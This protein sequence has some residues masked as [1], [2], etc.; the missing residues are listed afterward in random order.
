MQRGVYRVEKGH[1]S[2]QEKKT[3]RF[4]DLQFAEHYSLHGT[5]EQR[6]ASEFR[7]PLFEGFTMPS[8]LVC[9]ETAALVK[10]LL[11]RPLSVRLSE[12]PADIQLVEAFAPA[13]APGDGA[14]A[15]GRSWLEFAQLQRERAFVARQ[16]F[17]DR[18]E[19]PS[20]WETAEVLETLHQMY[21][22]NQRETDDNDGE[23]GESAA[24]DELDLDWGPVLDPEWCP[25]SGKPRATVELYTA[26]VGEDVAANLEGLARARMEKPPR[27]YQTDAAIH[28][29]YM[30]STTGGGEGGDGEDAPE[31]EPSGEG[32]Q[33][34]RSFFSS[35][36]PGVSLQ[37]KR[38]RTF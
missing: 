26:L 8:Q 19:W 28:Q 14:T 12:E 9:S 11:L 35:P 24:G 7:V 21:L 6:L 2:P 10:Q 33:R 20:I 17:L 37:W 30:K 31:A 13:C 32:P 3:R 34:A 36:C 5:H 25:D 1:R 38:W 15:F 16:R 27:Q 18:Y 23:V 4:I 29:A 22:E